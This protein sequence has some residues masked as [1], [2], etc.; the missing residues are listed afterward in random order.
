MKIEDDFMQY[1]NDDNLKDKHFTTNA[2]LSFNY[3]SSS[4]F[5][6]NE[7]SQELLDKLESIKQEML[8]GEGV[9]FNNIED[10]KRRYEL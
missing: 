7:V 6:E 10:L 8:S 3:I 1:L 5:E 2:S 9:S 4:F